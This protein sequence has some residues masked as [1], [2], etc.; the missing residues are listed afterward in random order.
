M[1]KRL[2][3][4]E[5]KEAAEEQDD[6]LCC[7]Q[8]LLRQNFRDAVKD[9]CHIT[10]KFRGAAHNACNLKLRIKPKTDQ[11]P[12]VFHNLKGYDAHHLMQA[13]TKLKLPTKEEKKCGA[14]N[15]DVKCVAN[16]M[17][18]YITFSFGGLKFIDS[19]SFLL[20]SLEKC[21]EST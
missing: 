14:N 10:G 4:E 1:L 2:T 15:M 5:H 19:L 16:N 3:E 17:E 11:I 6:C 21:V 8:P 9:H 13:M 12:V 18:K 20:T 7:G